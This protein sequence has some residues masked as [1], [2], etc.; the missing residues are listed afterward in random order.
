MSQ[1]STTLSEEKRLLENEVSRLEDLLSST[2]AER[3]EI[4]SK[5]LAV[6][7][8]VNMVLLELPVSL[9]CQFC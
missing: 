9:H 7:E 6:S 1:P 5:Y 3:D 8:R 4:S 2:R